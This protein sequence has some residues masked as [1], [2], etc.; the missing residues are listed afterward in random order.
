MKN[1]IKTR[2][3]ETAARVSFVISEVKHEREIQKSKDKIGPYK[4]A[5][6]PVQIWA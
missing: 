5:T 6:I 4:P 3:L 1:R 2:V